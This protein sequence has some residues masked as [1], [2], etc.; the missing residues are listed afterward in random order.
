M[1]PL[2]P[3][4]MLHKSCGRVM[5]AYKQHWSV[6]AGGRR[7]SF[8]QRGRLG[9][10]TQIQTSEYTFKEFPWESRYILWMVVGH[11]KV[12]TIGQQLY[13]SINPYS[14]R[15]DFVTHSDHM[16]PVECALHS[17]IQW[18]EYTEGTFHLYFCSWNRESGP[19]AD[20]F[21][22]VFGLRN[23]ANMNDSTSLSFLGCPM[24]LTS[25]W[26]SERSSQYLLICSFSLTANPVTNIQHRN[27]NKNI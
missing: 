23:K 21:G 22:T 8:V 7:G 24:N 11:F 17:Q 6:G 20:T 14:C 25:N 18:S 19:Y 5:I 9:L 16:S 26:V 2:S 10:K 13:S 1:F 27:R 4:S 15:S 12:V 3:R